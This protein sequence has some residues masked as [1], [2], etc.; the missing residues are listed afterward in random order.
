MPSAQ[1]EH[2][3]IARERMNVDDAN[4][5]LAQWREASPLVRAKQ[6]PGS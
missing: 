5:M 2:G 6:E 1:I 4:P 3:F